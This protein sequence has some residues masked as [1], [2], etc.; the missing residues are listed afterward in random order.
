MQMKIVTIDKD[1]VV[2]LNKKFFLLHIL[3]GDK[4]VINNMDWN[5]GVL[6]GYEDVLIFKDAEVYYGEWVDA[7]LV[8]HQVVDYDHLARELV[9]LLPQST[10]YFYLITSKFVLTLPTHLL[11]K[12]PPVDDPLISRYC[13]ILN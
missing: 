3:E 1:I 8:F 11:V 4:Y 12:L 6:E 9:K 13:R 2:N 10:E 5:F 7:N